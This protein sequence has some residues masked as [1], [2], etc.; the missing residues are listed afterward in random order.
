MACA[1]RDE[2]CGSHELL[3]YSASVL[4]SGGFTCIRSQQSMEDGH[5]YR[6]TT[7][8]CAGVW[9]HK[10]AC[11]RTPRSLSA[12]ASASGCRCRCAPSLAVADRPVSVVGRRWPSLAVVL[13]PAPAALCP[14]SLL[15]LSLPQPRN[16]KLTK[17]ATDTPRRY[18]TRED[19]NTPCELSFR[20]ELRTVRNPNKCS[21]GVCPAQEPSAGSLGPGSQYYR[22]HDGPRS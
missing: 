10:A 12:G 13:A 18:L 3:A 21:D 11:D 15:L 17:V 5:G 4:A 22:C 16:N 9:S 2:R 20:Q 7:Y 19:R 1:P 8:R 6:D 14:F